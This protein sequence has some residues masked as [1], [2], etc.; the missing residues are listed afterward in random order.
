MKNDGENPKVKAASREQREQEQGDPR[1]RKGDSALVHG[2]AA[3]PRDVGL[4]PPALGRASPH[5]P[6]SRQQGTFS[7]VRGEHVAAGAKYQPVFWALTVKNG[8]W[9][10]KGQYLQH[11]LAGAGPGHGL[12]LAGAGPGRGWSWPGLVLAVGSAAPAAARF[13]CSCRSRQC[14]GSCYAW[15]GHG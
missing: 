8:I 10:L 3:S 12:V 14:C 9:G 2:D 7:S 4:S 15:H 5:P 13:L 6:A 1:A 11:I